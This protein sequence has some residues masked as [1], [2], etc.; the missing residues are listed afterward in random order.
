LIFSGAARFIVEKI[1]PDGDSEKFISRRNE[2]IQAL[3]N[4]GCDEQSTEE[5]IK[6]SWQHGARLYHKNEDKDNWDSDAKNRWLI[7]QLSYAVVKSYYD[8]IKD[9]KKVLSCFPD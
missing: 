6:K 2:M 8:I 5:Q 1:W 9:A 4:L 7:H 3:E